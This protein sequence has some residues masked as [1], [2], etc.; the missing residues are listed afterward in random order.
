M[1]LRKILSVIISTAVIALALAGC[2]GGEVNPSATGGAQST[3]SAQGGQK[4]AVKVAGLKGPTGIGMVKL[5]QDSKKGGAQND[6]S[7]ELVGAPDNIVSM[8]SN[9]SVD[10]AAVPTNMAATL[11]N[12]TGGKVKL[13]ALNTLGVLY[14]LEKGESIQSI[15]D[16]KD[17]TIYATGQASTPEY[18][19]NY[20]LEANGLKAGQDVKVEYLAEHSELAAKAL[21][22]Q[23]DIIMLPEPFVTTVLSKDAGFRVAVDLNNEWKEASEDSS[24]FSMG[25]LMVRTEFLENNKAAVDKFLEEYA[26]SVKYVNENVDAAAELVAAENIM[27]SK[28]LAAKAIPNCNIVY[29]EGK[30]MQEKT[31]PFLKLLYDNNPKSV[32][33]SLPGEDFYYKK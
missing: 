9:G 28:E 11:Y 14:I 24:I 22:G 6:Y 1:K 18:A 15:A 32:G 23:A 13:L 21:A 10:I 33:G 16:L 5:M 4:T 27:A 20:I 30:E 17:K 25:A 7:F 31:Q 8:I 19:L 12:K 29:I 2:T 26:A 3:Q